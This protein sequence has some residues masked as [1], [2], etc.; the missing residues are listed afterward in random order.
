MN[1][2]TPSEDPSVLVRDFIRGLL[3][4]ASFLECP[5]PALRTPH[6]FFL[7]EGESLFWAEVAQHPF[8]REEIPDYLAKARQ[9]QTVFPAGV[10]GILIAPQFEKGVAELF[11]WMRLTVRLFCYEA[12]KTPE[13]QTCPGTSPEPPP[14]TWN[15]LTREELREFIQIELDLLSHDFHK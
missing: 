6:S 8:T 10:T 12:G 1:G 11:E 2:R 7:R 13:I 9:I 4:K 15:R 5:D 14:P 3:P